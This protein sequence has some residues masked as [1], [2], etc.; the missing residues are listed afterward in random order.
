MKAR[1]PHSPSLKASAASVSMACSFKT[2]SLS[3]LRTE[4]GESPG[5]GRGPPSRRVHPVLRQPS[6]VAR[7]SSSPTRG[8]TGRLQLISASSKQMTEK[9]AHGPLTLNRKTIL[10]LKLSLYVSN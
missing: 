6:A 5:H 4:L 9:M 10:F 2:G 7:A 3:A 8:R 1:S